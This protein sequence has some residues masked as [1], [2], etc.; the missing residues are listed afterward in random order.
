[1]TGQRAL[2]AAPSGELLV[3]EWAAW[4]QRGHG[5]GTVGPWWPQEQAHC[6]PGAL[7][8]EAPGSVQNLVA[9][10]HFQRVRGIMRVITTLSG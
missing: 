3:G 9:C 2:V 8:R 5:T 4:A 10:Q 6:S 1:M 7:A